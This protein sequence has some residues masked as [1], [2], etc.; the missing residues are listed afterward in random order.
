MRELQHDEDEDPY[1]VFGYG[2]TAYFKMLEILIK[3]FIGMVIL[4]APITFL[5]YHGYAFDHLQGLNKYM[6]PFTLGNIGHAKTDCQYH[7]LQN[8][9]PSHVQCAKG[10][11]TELHFW[12]MMP[13]SKGFDQDFCGLWNVYQEIEHCTNSHINQNE[14]KKAFE[15]ECLGE[16]DCIFDF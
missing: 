6:A 5:Y 2:I 16:E 7:F 9:K 14:F 3:L 11:I 12:G 1:E 13:N 10:K 4:M 15:E 8:P